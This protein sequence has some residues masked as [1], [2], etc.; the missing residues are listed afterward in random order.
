MTLSELFLGSIQKNQGDTLMQMKAQTIKRSDK[1]DDTAFR[2]I[3][4]SRMNGSAQQNK[5]SA[6][7]S[8]YEGSR[9]A[10][11]KSDAADRESKYLSFHE[12]KRASAA[13]SGQKAKVTNG[14]KKDESMD[15][16]AEDAKTIAVKQ[17]RAAEQMLSTLAQL[18]GVTLNE[19]KQLLKDADL[20]L[21]ALTGAHDMKEVLSLLSE[22]FGLNMKQ[23]AALGKIL[24]IMDESMDNRTMMESN[25][26]G[27]Q[28]I[29]E[30]V[31]TAEVVSTAGT[32]QEAQSDLSL[33]DKL[34][35][36]LKSLIKSKLD[37]ITV[38]WDADQS[39]AEAELK[40]MIQSLSS[41]SMMKAQEMIGQS[42]DITVGE[43]S[44]QSVTAVQT[45]EET[46]SGENE[47]SGRE[48]GTKADNTAG[49]QQPLTAA[50]QNP[51]LS[52]FAV[53]QQEQVSSVGP[54][55]MAEVSTPITAREIVS[56]VVE[57]AKIILTSEKS[58]MVMELKPDSLGKISL[59]V[60]TENGIVMAKFIAESQQ[61]KQVLET[62]MQ[63]LKDSLERQGMNVQGFSVSV[64][65]DSERPSDN[66][67]QQEQVRSRGLNGT[68][69]R[70]SGIEG[71]LVDMME[72]AATSSPYQWESSTINLTA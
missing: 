5:V 61:V 29:L 7:Y 51:Q 52:A 19:L 46:S 40:Q 36:E 15:V 42:A 20:K 72:S 67:Y 38:H 17:K 44:E 50:D 63:L 64:R 59:K 71:S 35:E 55:K 48:A 22:A 49:V 9:K 25:T 16:D 3:L 45:N 43:S 60:V 2:D 11:L 6:N 23:E 65:Q 68:A 12:A 56:Q 34:T 30:G 27:N 10:E 1:S 28:Q 26:D 69:Y 4:G 13:D 14:N 39:G 18:M 57:N 8:S 31:K 66:R 58:E 33:T 24:E 53:A 21:E 47:R 32:S 41:K 37:E 54:A 70:T 62:N